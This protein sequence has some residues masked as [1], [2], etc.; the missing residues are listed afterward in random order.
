MRLMTATEASR[1]FAALLDAAEHGESVVI[2]RAGRR[3]AIIGPAPTGNG[4]A[5]NDILAA[6]APDPDF[7]DDV[8][9]ARTLVTDEPSASWPDD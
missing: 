6:H 5:L 1:N 9:A 8:R 3:L 7:A 4:A 2:T